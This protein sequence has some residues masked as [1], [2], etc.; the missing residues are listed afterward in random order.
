MASVVRGAALGDVLLLG[1]WTWAVLEGRAG[2]VD[3]EEGGVGHGDE[4]EGGV[5]A[6]EAMRPG[7]PAAVAE[8]PTSVLCVLPAVTAGELWLA[9]K[10]PLANVTG[11]D[12]VI[13]SDVLFK[14]L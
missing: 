1:A 11:E 12:V 9:L 14:M 2:L 13:L 4:G 7:G 6:L 8:V 3:K 5:G 10:V